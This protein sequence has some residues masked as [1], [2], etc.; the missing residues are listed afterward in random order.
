MTQPV[1]YI[2]RASWAADLVAL[3]DRHDAEDPVRAPGVLEQLATSA[4]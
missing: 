3:A 4:R 1:R 2:D